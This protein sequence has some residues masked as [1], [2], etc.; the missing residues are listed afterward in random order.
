ME[1]IEARFIRL[2]PYAW[3]GHVSMRMELY[4]CSLKPGKVENT[5]WYTQWIFLPE[6]L[7]SSTPRQPSYWEKSSVSLWSFFL[8]YNFIQIVAFFNSSICYLLYN[9]LVL[10]I[11]LISLS[12]IYLYLLYL[13]LDTVMYNTYFTHNKKHLE[14]SPL[15]ARYNSYSTDASLQY[16]TMQYTTLYRIT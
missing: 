13:Q 4:G 15:T 3:Y 10:E 11:V 14:Y 9:S 1:P 12:E 7:T 2:H 6:E 16:A 8:F 5:S